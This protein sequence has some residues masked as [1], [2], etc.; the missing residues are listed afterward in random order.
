MKRGRK[1][2]WSGS[3]IATAA[4]VSLCVNG[5]AAAQLFRKPA[6]KDNSTANAAKAPEQAKTAEPVPTPTLTPTRHMVSPNE[7][8]AIVNGEPISRQQLADECVVVKGEEVLDTLIARRLIDQALKAKHLEV[9]A[10]EVDAEIDRVASSVAGVTRQQWLKELDEKRKISPARYARDVIYPML[11]LKKLAAPLVQITDQD[12]KEACQAQFGERV[13]CRMILLNSLP[14]AKDVWEQVRK[15]PSRFET[16]AQ[17][18]SIDPATRSV[19]G[20]MPEPIARFAQPREVSDKVFGQLVDSSEVLDPKSPEADKNRPKNG[21]FT[22]VIQVTGETWAIFQ[23]VELLEAKP[24][25]VNDPTLQKQIKEAIYEGKLQEK[26]GEL[27]AGLM[28]DAAVEN[29][30]TGRI[31]LSREEEM[32]APADAQIQRSA[33]QATTPPAAGA[34]AKPTAPPAGK[35]GAL[36]PVNP[37]GLSA[38]DAKR[39]GSLKK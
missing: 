26:I 18:K 21:A 4:V 5:N 37:V 36:P 34:A 14:I 31:K 27:L 35:P 17:E 15:D 24:Y 12:M 29:R 20:M 13:K 23:R 1:R 2:A 38:E 22:G 8:I 28:R 32:H 9:T 16:L 3:A 7:P 6:A 30:L 10:A 33:T 11:A 25:N 19:G 39:A